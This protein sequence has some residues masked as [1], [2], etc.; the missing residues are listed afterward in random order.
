MSELEDTKN[1]FDTSE[2]RNEIKSQLKNQ[3]K[4]IAS[5]SQSKEDS[6]IW[7]KKIS[8]GIV[9]QGKCGDKAY[10]H[11]TND[12]TLTIYGQGATAYYHN[13]EKI[14]W[15]EYRSQIKNV[16]I[17]EG[18]IELGNNAF[19]ELYW[20]E[21]VSFP[22]SLKFMCEGVFSGSTYTLLKT[23]HI[24]NSVQCITD[25]ISS[26]FNI[27]IDGGLD[28]VIEGTC[29][30]DAKFKFDKNT[31]TLRIY[32]SGNIATLNYKWH[33]YKERIKKVYIEDKIS[34]IPRQAFIDCHNLESVYMTNNVTSI[35]SHAFN[36]C[37]SLKKISI[38]Q[39]IIIHN[40]AFN[41]CTSLSKVTI[42]KTVVSIGEY[43]FNN[44]S[45]NLVVKAP[46]HLKGRMKEHDYIKIEYY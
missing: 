20:L 36:S 37:I 43:I 4:K 16:V 39:I 10:W 31:G 12:G 13:V 25:P 30:P 24:P 35:N 8:F 27:E 29:G 32:G 11:L 41:S 5:Q 6:T 45:P 9:D 46:K 33:L 1:V 38:P 19:N 22:N 40:D 44:C 3:L 23:L 26:Q 28:S 21:N 17:K 7:Q 42:P 18:I 2:L 34:N 14:P 15:R